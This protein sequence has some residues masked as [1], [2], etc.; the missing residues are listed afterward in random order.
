MSHIDIMARRPV[1]ARWIIATDSTDDHVC[2][3]CTICDDGA[4]LHRDDPA[5]VEFITRHATA[6]CCPVCHGSGQLPG[7]LAVCH[8]HTD[9]TPML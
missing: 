5:L 1:G 6:D 7:V 2:I 3:D 4:E 8:H 9:E